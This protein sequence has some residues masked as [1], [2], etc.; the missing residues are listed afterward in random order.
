M[1]SFDDFIWLITNPYF[2]ALFVFA[3]ALEPLL[4]YLRRFYPVSLQKAAN[5]SEKFSQDLKENIEERKIFQKSNMKVFFFI[6]GPTIIVFLSYIV[7]KL[8]IGEELKPICV[9]DAFGKISTIGIVT[10]GIYTIKSD[11][12]NKLL[13]QDDYEKTMELTKKQMGNDPFYKYFE[14]YAPFFGY[15]FVLLGIIGFIGQI[16]E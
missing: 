2:I 8:I 9:R 5:E 6:F 16:Y 1:N 11:Q 3:L 10:L 7:Y 12:I 14:K 4:K 13:F 15:L